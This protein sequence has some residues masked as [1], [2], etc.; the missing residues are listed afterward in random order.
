MNKTFKYSRNGL[1]FF[2]LGILLFSTA[3]AEY[4]G[5]YAGAAFRYGASARSVA[6]GDALVAEPNQ[7]FQQLVNPAMITAVQKNELGVSL[8]SMSLDRSIQVISL[9]RN[10]PPKGAAG[11]MIYRAGTSDIQGRNTIGQ[12]T[13]MMDVS[14]MYGMLTFGL[15]MKY[16]LSAGISIKALFNDIDSDLDGS[17]ISAD[18]GLLYRY[19]DDLTLGVALKDFAGA[20][21]WNSD[22]VSIEEELPGQFLIGTS[23][24]PI[25]NTRLMAEYE[26][27]MISDR[28]VEG[29]IKMGLESS[30]YSRLSLR[31]GLI[32][33]KSMSNGDSEEIDLDVKFGIGVI[34]PLW[35]F[36]N[37]RFDYALE[38]GIKGEGIS[39]LISWS[40]E[41]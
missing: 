29:R 20:T 41:I 2:I 38:P 26:S 16:G 23:I 25:E 8:Y 34:Y 5:G 7:G 17:G 37:L 4:G 39:H 15:Q 31:L 3:M 12:K 27:F 28:G 6:L 18:F 14:D 10:L 13:D 35:K 36:N 11:L 1:S 21:T 40:F 32:G 24:S 9:S 19:S 33:G 22:G 30:F